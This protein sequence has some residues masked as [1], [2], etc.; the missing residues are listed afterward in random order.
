MTPDPATSH[1]A[2]TGSEWAGRVMSS[3]IGG[4]RPLSEESLTGK[5]EDKVVAAD[6]AP[7]MQVRTGLGLL[8][9]N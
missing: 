7:G 5:Q 1:R 8:I 9:A 3:L 2:Q 4:R 6:T